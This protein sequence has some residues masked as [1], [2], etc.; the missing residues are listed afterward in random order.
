MIY[1]GCVVGIILR[2]SRNGICAR[3]SGAGN[4]GRFLHI[5]SNKFEMVTINSGKILKETGE[6]N[7]YIA[8]AASSS[9]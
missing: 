9:K 4:T 8:G 6:L 2:A 7:E 3:P 5:Y 1:Y